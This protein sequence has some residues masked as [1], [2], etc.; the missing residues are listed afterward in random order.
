MTHLFKKFTQLFLAIL[1][2]TAAPAQSA[3]S[4]SSLA[5]KGLGT[6]ATCVGIG[7]GST[8]AHEYG[9]AITAEILEPGSI[10]T[11]VIGA[12]PSEKTYP[13]STKPILFPEGL[14]LYNALGIVIGFTQLNEVRNSLHRIAISAAGP[15]G[16]AGFCLATLALANYFIPGKTPKTVQGYLACG[17][18]GHL[19]Q[20]VFG[21]DGRDIRKDLRL[22]KASYY[23]IAAPVIGAALYGMY[24]VAI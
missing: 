14:R 10:D 19:T 20:L 6:W 3:E 12:N 8:I 2:C 15:F 18:L 16:G 5:L 11:V 21:C 9:H 22:D 1:I 24:K 13:R 4:W 23:S 7:L 17:I